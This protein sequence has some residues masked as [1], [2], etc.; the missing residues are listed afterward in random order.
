MEESPIPGAE[1]VEAGL[2][3]GSGDEPVL[4]AAAVAREA[5]VAFEAV[6]RRLLALVQAELALPGRGDELKH[7]RL[8]DVAELVVGLHE[9]VAAVEIAVCSS[10]SASPQVSECTH[11]PGG[12]PTQ[13]ARATSNICT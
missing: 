1:V 5:N 6:V 3:V 10:A 9:V 8:L 2:T 4:W 12:S 11:S 7:V 13:F